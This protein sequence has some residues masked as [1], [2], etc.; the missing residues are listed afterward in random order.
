MI[1]NK[2]VNKLSNKNKSCGNRKI[3]VFVLSQFYHE[4]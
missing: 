2:I 4:W 1:D 3:A